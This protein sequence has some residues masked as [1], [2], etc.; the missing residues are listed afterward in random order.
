MPYLTRQLS[1]ALGEEHN[2]E[3]RNALYETEAMWAMIMTNIKRM[4]VT[5]C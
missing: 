3:G 2:Q 4:S 1:L 5:S